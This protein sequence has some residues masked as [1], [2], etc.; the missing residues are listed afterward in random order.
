MNKKIVITTDGKT[1]LAR[2]Y[3]GKTLVK[4]TKSRCG[5]SDSF[6]LYFGVELALRRMLSA[7]NPGD[8]V[9]II[10]NSCCHAYPFGSIVTLKDRNLLCAYSDAWN[11][12]EGDTFLRERD[13]EPYVEPHKP[14]YWSGKVVCI[15]NKI[16]DRDFKVGKIYEVVDGKIVDEFG[17]PRPYEDHDI[18]IT[19][20]EALTLSVGYFAN[21]LYKF[22]PLVED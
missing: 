9:K 16:H 19:C 13:I 11:T 4:V 17:A 21:W 5:P 8:K 14:K 3:E 22:I 7:Y 18:R 10:R 12:K 1:T 20:P 2:L 6:D 15:E